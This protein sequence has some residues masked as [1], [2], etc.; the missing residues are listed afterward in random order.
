MVNSKVTTEIFV[1]VLRNMPN[2]EVVVEIVVETS[3]MENGE[4]KAE[5]GA[6][7]VLLG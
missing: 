3:F 5:I 4:V 2:R 1:E 7:I 6:E